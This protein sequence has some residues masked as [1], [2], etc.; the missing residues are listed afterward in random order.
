VE[1]HPLRLTRISA[2]LFFLSLFA[3]LASAGPRVASNYRHSLKVNPDRTVS[4]WG[5]NYEGQLGDGT[6]I[7]RSQPVQVVGLTNIIAVAAGNSHSLALRGDGTVWAWGNN[8]S[9]QLGVPG[10]SRSLAL[11]VPGLQN[12]VSI[13]AGARA[14]L[15][16]RSDGTV[17]A[18]GLNSSGVLGT[19]VPGN[20]ASATPV[21][22][23]GLADVTSISLTGS[24]GLAVR[25]D[26]LVL[27]WGSTGLYMMADIVPPLPYDSGVPTVVP[28]LNSVVAVA[29]G[30]SFSL[31]LK[32]DG[33]VWYW[34]NF[35]VGVIPT[36]DDI[37]GMHS[38]RAIPDFS[39]VKAIAAGFNTAAFLK[40]DG[41]VW[42]MGSVS[43][44][45]E[46]VTQTLVLPVRSLAPGP[47][48]EIAC[49]SATALAL[50]PDGT[51]LVWGDNSLS[52]AGISPYQATPVAV[53]GFFGVTSLAP[54][55][56]VTIALRPGGSL[57]TVGQSLSYTQG[58]LGLG[59]TMSAVTP[60]PIPNVTAVAAIS[61][62]QK[63]NLALN[64]DGTVLSWGYSGAMGDSELTRRTVPLPVAGLSGAT[65]ISAG[66]THSLAL[67]SDGTVWAWGSNGEGEVDPRSRSYTIIA[68]PIQVPGAPGGL[69]G[70]TACNYQ[71]L[72]LRADGAVFVWGAFPHASP[73]P[74]PLTPTQVDGLSGVIKLSCLATARLALKADGTVWVWGS[75][76]DYLGVQSDNSGK[77]V[78]LSTLSG[79]A[80][81]ASGNAHLLVRLADGSVWSLGKNSD[82]QLGDGTTEPRTLP[83]RV[84]GL[85]NV[86]SLAAAVNTSFAIRKDGSVYAWGSKMFGTLGTGE[87]GSL[88]APTPQPAVAPMDLSV[89]TKAPVNLRA[90]GSSPFTVTVTNNGGFPATGTSTLT[91]SPGPGLTLAGSPTGP[92]PCGAN[93]QAITCGSALTIPAYSSVSFTLTLS[94]ST[95]AVPTTTFTAAVSTP[96]DTNPSNDTTTLTVPVAPAPTG[97]APTITAFADLAGTSPR[98]TFTFTVRDPDGA[99]N[100]HYLQFHIAR[101]QT[102]SNSC[103]IH[104]DV[105]QNVFYLR[106][107]DATDWWGIYPGTNTRTGNS[108]CELY[109]ATT[110]AIKSGTDLNVTLDISF[111]GTFTG[112]RDV[113]ILAADLGSNITDWYQAGSF[114]VTSDPTL[115]ELVSVSPVAGAASSQLFT[116]TLRDGDGAGKVWFSQL[117]INSANNAAQ[118]CYVH[119][120]PATNVFYLLSDNGQSW[121]GLRA[122]SSDQVQNSQ[123]LLK[124]KNSTG[125]AN[126]QDLTV[127]Y[128]LQFKPSFAGPKNVYARASDLDGNLVQWKRTGTFQV[129]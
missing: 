99:T 79:V 14:S 9:A 42:T 95:A 86:D 64:S 97:A 47:V 41:S 59:T 39:S 23:V 94:A 6:V 121:A 27:A 24:H 5:D 89:V 104:Y 124:G 76:Y 113:F 111:R 62:S 1:Y 108:Q 13:A 114:A 29:A 93:G 33:T 77:P 44:N 127:T 18:W 68:P 116:M 46:P 34:G 17:W 96:G 52:G 110:R 118:G 65:A 129:R 115:L 8:S 66:V 11:Q 107:D 35:A 43:G 73:T 61:A 20:T 67:R 30:T 101:P 69:I 125:T 32:S 56:T 112:N 82:G 117:N 71:S 53:P 15:A 128:D 16:L 48:E 83:V 78:Q 31:A 40:N 106:N 119:F 50:R 2:A 85:T 100:L 3:S 87:F 12:I 54:A 102:E 7:S 19:A 91:L 120:D 21:Q 98:R 122:G 105:A 22:V 26:G 37:L 25:K 57:L 70:V 36:P 72:A 81:I 55:S 51:T 74:S 58:I 109:A 88:L 38:P 123:C 4:A 84:A 75:N 90:G 63:Y 92:W 28:V 126:G 80:D 45:G 49:G 103:L 10:P 60:T